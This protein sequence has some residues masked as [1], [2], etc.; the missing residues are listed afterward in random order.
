MKQYK[1][2]DERNYYRDNPRYDIIEDSE[3]MF[4]LRDLEGETRKGLLILNTKKFQKERVVDEHEALLLM[5]QGIKLE[6]IKHD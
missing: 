3:R 5:I 2:V 1:V 6:E 4:S